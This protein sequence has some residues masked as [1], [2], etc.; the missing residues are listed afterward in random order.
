[1]DKM[2]VVLITILLKLSGFFMKQCKYSN[3]NQPP[4]KVR[5]CVRNEKVASVS[6]SNDS[7][8]LL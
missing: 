8:P 2:I 6:R 4:G 3:E 5:F 1:M 7:L